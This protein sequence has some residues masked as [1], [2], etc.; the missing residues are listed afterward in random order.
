V[1]RD[2][3][4]PGLPRERVLALVVRLLETTLI[5]VG[6]PEYARRNRSFGLT[7]LRRRHVDIHGR[8]VE[9]HFRGK[10]GKQREVALDDRRLAGIVRRCQDL[11]GYELFQYL[12]K[13]GGRHRV[14]ADDVND[15]LQ[16]V[17][18]QPFTAK[19]FR[20]WAGTVLAARTFRELGHGASQTDSRRRVSEAIKRVARRLGNTPAICRKCYVHPLVV[21]AYLDGSL[22]E[23]LERK[24]ARELA[25]KHLDPEEVQVLRFIQYRLKQ[26]RE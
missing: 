3:S 4:R 12:D 25:E 15:Y 14:A 19:D 13:E 22:V 9:F 20:T 26:Q 11:P 16:A 24:A 7:T 2:L 10:G 23:T 6:H 8:R 18:G 17:T 1:E 5:R 21:E